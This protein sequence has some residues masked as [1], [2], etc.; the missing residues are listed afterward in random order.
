MSFKWLSLVAALAL[1]L[2]TA[3]VAYAQGGVITGTVTS[4]G[5]WPLPD[6]IL[7]KV[8]SPGGWGVF[9]QANVDLDT[10]AF[11][12]GPVPNGLYILRAVP[13]A[14][15][16]YTQ[17][18][19]VPVSVFNAPVD[20]G[21][22]PLTEP[23]I[24]GTVTAPDSV[25]LVPAEVGVHTG[26][27]TL[28][29]RVEA[30]GGEFQVGGLAAGSYGL[31][32]SPTTDDPYWHSPLKTV[33]VNGYAQTI[34]L[35]LSAADVYGVANDALGNPVPDATVYATRLA[36]SV[37][38][39]RQQRDRTSGSGYYAIGGLYPGTYLLTAKPPWYEGALLPPRPISFALPGAT[40]PYTLTFR[41]PPKLVT[42]VVETNTGIPVVNAEVVAHRLDKG[43]HARTLTGVGGG[44]RIDLSDGLWALTVKPI[45]TTDITLYFRLSVCHD[46]FVRCAVSVGVEAERL[47]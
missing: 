29:Q 44:Y 39:H 40:P 1:L 8:F 34:T 28:I 18:E 14:G 22:V 16:E 11:S 9:G 45:N 19:P 2:A 4:P 46:E 35:T 42:G 20:V 38:D 25:T 10:G 24:L 17:S 13:P 23:E 21:V 7:V 15:S 6:G 27:G 26:A 30:I 33:T 37:V 3:S 41:A 12:L 5:G 31:R 47:E 36:A 32:A 43:G